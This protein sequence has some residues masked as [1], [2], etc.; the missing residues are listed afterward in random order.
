MSANNK[1]LFI[2]LLIAL[3]ILSWAPRSKAAEESKVSEETL[4]TITTDLDSDYYKLIVGIDNDN[5]ALKTFFVDNFSRGKLTK[6]DTMA[7]NV[8]IRDGI[9]F[10]K[11]GR[12]T[13]AKIVPENFDEDQGGMVTIDAL[14]NILTG[15][16]KSYELQLAKD[17]EGWKLFTHGKVIKQIIAH[18]NKVPFLGVVGAKDLVMK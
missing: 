7:I 1:L 5:Q 6:R 12:I 16:I 17:K 3:F 4:A 15:R 8:F 9:T 13:F 11:K 14:Y 10:N 2:S 18:A